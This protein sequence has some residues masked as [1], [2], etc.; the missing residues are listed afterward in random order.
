MIDHETLTGADM[1]D[2]R[3]LGAVVPAQL[4]PAALVVEDDPFIRRERFRPGAAELFSDANNEAARVFRQF[5]QYGRSGA[6]SWPLL[7]VIMRASSFGDLAGWASAKV[8]AARKRRS[9]RRS[10][11]SAIV[12]R[13]SGRRR[14][15]LLN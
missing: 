5:A 9:I 3:A 8:A 6:P 1:V 7:P 2:Q 12:A 11:G 10:K 14:P 4:E 15:F 13:V